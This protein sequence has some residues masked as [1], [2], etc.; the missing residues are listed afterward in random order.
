MRERL[1]GLTPGETAV[2]HALY[3][4]RVIRGLEPV[5]ST[6]LC[7]IAGVERLSVK[8]LINHI[9]RKRPDLGVRSIVG[10]HGGYW[11]SNQGFQTIAR[12]VA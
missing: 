1:N 2:A 12:A 11:L 4:M 8:V 3:T 5:S 9:R 10:A 7:E 6:E